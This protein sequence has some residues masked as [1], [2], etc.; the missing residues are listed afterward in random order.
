[1]ATMS[2]QIKGAI[3]GHFLKDAFMTDKEKQLRDLKIDT[4]IKSHQLSDLDILRTM[5]PMA[6][7]E[8]ELNIAKN[9]V[10]NIKNKSSNYDPL[11]RDAIDSFGEEVNQKSEFYNAYKLSVTDTYNKMSDNE[12]KEIDFDN[13]TFETISSK[14]SEIRRL[15][16]MMDMGHSKE[17]NFSYTPKGSNIDSKIIGS[18]LDEYSNKLDASLFYLLDVGNPKARGENLPSDAKRAIQIGDKDALKQIKNR[19][20]ALHQNNFRKNYS[21]YQSYNNQKMD[22]DSRKTPEGTVNLMPQN[23]IKDLQEK[24]VADEYLDSLKD[25]NPEMYSAFMGG[26]TSNKA[27]LD[28]KL[29]SDFLKTNMSFLKQNITES[30]QGFRDWTGSDISTFRGGIDYSKVRQAFGGDTKFLDNTADIDD[31]NLKKQPSIP[32]KT[33]VLEGL[34]KHIRDA[35]SEDLSVSNL[36]NSPNISQSTKNQI[37]RKSTIK[38][39]N[40][41]IEDSIINIV[42]PS[43]QQYHDEGMTQE[44]TRRWKSPGKGQYAGT[45]YKEESPK[46]KYK[47]RQLMIKENKEYREKKSKIDYSHPEF[48]IADNERL[49]KIKKEG[50]RLRAELN[51]K[52]RKTIKNLKK[53]EQSELKQITGEKITKQLDKKE[54]ISMA[55]DYGVAGGQP[56]FKNMSESQQRNLL[57]LIKGYKNNLSLIEN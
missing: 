53:R 21:L 22:A 46:I 18:R 34:P 17:F 51:S 38:K 39:I 30:N 54:I 6:N 49:K 29:Y 40:K 12:F 24:G 7:T 26:T 37:S 19:E 33:V 1:M 8:A 9:T 27:V 45:I 52:Y 20:I 13:M 28:Y 44:K 16:H 32:T 23:M 55:L 41:K 15:K 47:Y 43:L 4:S 42:K 25:F 14:V 50:D 3:I 36:I 31:D 56:W 11:I 57:S 2:E 10:K 48:M 5:I 35:L